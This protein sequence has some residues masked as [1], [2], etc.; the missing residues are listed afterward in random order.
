[1]RSALQSPRPVPPRTTRAGNAVP[2]LAAVPDRV[3]RAGRASFV[4]LLLLVLS[5][6]LAALLGFNT[7]L[8]QGSFTAS[9]LQKEA[10]AL[11]D[12]SQSLEEALARAAAPDRLAKAARDIG[13]VPA[14]GVS[15]VSLADG[16]VT[17]GAVPAPAAPKPLTPEERAELEARQK[18]EAE[19]AAAEKQAR[20]ERVTARQE[21]AAAAAE[22][23]RARVAAERA[24]A[25]QQAAQEKAEKEWK[26][27]LAE[28]EKGGSRAGGEQVVE[29][30][31]GTWSN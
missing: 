18:L 15:F 16:T 3:P 17:D 19:Q 24:A 29:P 1:M 14:P 8:A 9:K 10:T 25:A 13:M 31:S 30:P 27:K 28:Q 4:M 23:E 20:A 22:A 11:E 7:A 2:T 26:R 6:G 12:R 5:G 21:R